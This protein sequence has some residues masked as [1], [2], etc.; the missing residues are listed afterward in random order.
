MQL[1]G[2]ISYGPNVVDCAS[3][4][5]QFHADCPLHQY[6]VR[7]DHN[8]DSMC[9][10]HANWS[11]PD[12][13]GA[14][15]RDGQRVLP[16]PPTPEDKRAQQS[17]LCGEVTAWANASIR[18]VQRHLNQIPVRN[19]PLPVPRQFQAAEDRAARLHS[20][21]CE[22]K[23]LETATTSFST[24]PMEVQNLINQGYA[25]ETRWSE[26]RRRARRSPGTPSL[27]ER[28]RDPDE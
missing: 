24:G 1:Y 13:S 7:I 19:P 14:W 17:A 8:D 11:V 9:L 21:V 15:L 26:T 12:N 28:Q 5:D 27:S 10:D 3:P 23:D 16:C 20:E 18:E 22:A 25:A 4:S 2:R 6:L